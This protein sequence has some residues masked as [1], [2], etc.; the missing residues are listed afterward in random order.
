MGIIGIKMA[1]EL[2]DLVSPPRKR[3]K[4]TCWGTLAL[5][6][7]GEEQNGSNVFLL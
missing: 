3:V 2:G 7:F 5:Q 4:S 6:F 1:L